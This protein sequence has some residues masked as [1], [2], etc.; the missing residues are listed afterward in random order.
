MNIELLLQEGVCDCVSTPLSQTVQTIRQGMSLRGCS[1][2]Q[3]SVPVSLPGWVIIP[4]QSCQ[5]LNISAA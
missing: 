4:N 5:M 2:K 3:R 1:E